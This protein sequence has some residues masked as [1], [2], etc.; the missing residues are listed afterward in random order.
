MAPI[1]HVARTVTF[2]VGGQTAECALT[3]VKIGGKADVMTSYTLCD[4][5]PLVE[6][7]QPSFT[8][9]L[10][11]NASHSGLFGY[12]ISHMGDTVAFSYTTADGSSYAGDCVIG[13]ADA[14]APVNQWETGSASLPI[15][16]NPFA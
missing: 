7:G 9:D 1:G 6:A 14:T 12:L 10:Q 16:G 2:S 3:S 8:L 15:V 11:F 13:S 4:G 5:G